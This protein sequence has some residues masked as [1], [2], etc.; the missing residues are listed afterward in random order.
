MAVVDEQQAILAR[1]RP[2]DDALR[3]DQLIVPAVHDE[4]RHACTAVRQDRRADHVAHRRM[5]V[6]TRM[7]RALAGGAMLAWG[8]PAL[9]DVTLAPLPYEDRLEARTLDAIDLVV[10][11]CTELPDLA[12][13]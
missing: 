12:T 1:S 2:V 5:G 4:G 6:G 3:G 10:I 13:A 9:L 7:R 8:M 11:H